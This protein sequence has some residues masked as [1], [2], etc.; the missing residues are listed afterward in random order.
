MRALAFAMLAL[1]ATAAVAQTQPLLGG[2]ARIHDPTW[3]EIEGT[4]IAFGT[5]VE[6]APDGG[7]I[8]VKTSADGID[9]EDAGTIGEGIPAWVEG[10]I[11][12]VPPN[13]WA[14]HVLLRDGTAFLY[15]SAS[16]FGKNTSAIG[17]MTNAAL[18]PQRPTEGWIDQGIVQLSG[19]ADNFNAIDPARID[20]PDGRAWLA[21][22]SWWDGI[23]LRELDPTTG[24]LLVEDEPVFALA[25]R[26]GGAIE[27]PSILE[28]DGRYYLFVAFDLCCRGVASTYSIRVGRADAVTGPY[29][30][31]DGRPMLDGGGTIVQA[32]AGRMRGPGGQEAYATMDGDVLVYHYY[33]L[34]AGGVPKLQIS[35]LHWTDDGWPY[36]DAAPE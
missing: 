35:P 12:A 21:F 23:K 25:S 22:G 7:A 19:P 5:G 8:R 16:R 10:A 2:D 28:R 13:L 29:L 34:E 26:H 24:K 20:T 14:P 30:D 17:L 9:W 1:F 33:D 32:T 36:L 15:Y 4:Q 18:E 27:A 31:R 3:I 6:R 11:G